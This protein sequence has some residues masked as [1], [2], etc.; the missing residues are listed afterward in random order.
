[1]PPKVSS[2]VWSRSSLSFFFIPPFVFFP[3]STSSLPSSPLTT[4]LAATRRLIRSGILPVFHRPARELRRKSS[5]WSEFFALDGVVEGLA[6]GLVSGG[7]SGGGLRA[8]ARTD[9]PRLETV[10]GEDVAV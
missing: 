10:R 1:M 2:R 3:P 7:W 9:P 5:R 8:R 4:Q 6:G